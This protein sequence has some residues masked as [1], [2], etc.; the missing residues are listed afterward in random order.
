MA[1][2][3]D[4]E[5]GS[6]QAA[7]DPSAPVDTMP[8]GVVERGPTSTAVPD[9]SQPVEAHTITPDARDAPSA[10][11]PRVEVSA[12]SRSLATPMPDPPSSDDH[13]FREIV[14][15]HGTYLLRLALVLSGIKEVAE[16]LVQDTFNRAWPRFGALPPDSHVR[17]WLAK[18]L[19]R[20]FLD[21][22]KHK[23]V[24]ER[25][26][27]KLSAEEDIA[28][29]SLLPEISHAALRDAIERL[30]PELREIIE[31]YLTRKSY[32]E[33]AEELDIPLG[34][35]SSRMRRAILHLKGLFTPTGILK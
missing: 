18:I 26:R 34:T 24:V 6:E 14:K 33:I 25:A 15:Q 17:A 30:E 28:D 3:R 12:S 13:A 8:Q 23:D 2:S 9:S 29:D 1:K 10:D 16:D 22:N 19:T 35:V 11:E 21:Y 20:R 27:L 32:K 31:C 7:S 5:P 4:E